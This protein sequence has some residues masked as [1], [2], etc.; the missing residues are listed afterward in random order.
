M[1]YL[2]RVVKTSDMPEN[3]F[4]YLYKTS[5]L[6]EDGFTEWIV[7]DLVKELDELFGKKDEINNIRKLDEWLIS[8]SAKYG[9]KVLIEH[10]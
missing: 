6:I 9:E 7:G 5:L 3:L 8:Q 1:S 4:D 2:I 10:G